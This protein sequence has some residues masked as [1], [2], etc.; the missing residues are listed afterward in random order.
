VKR[1]TVLVTLKAAGPL[2]TSG[3]GDLNRGLQ[4]IF[5][6]DAMGKPIL[7]ASHIKGKLLEALHEL[8]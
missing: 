3:G 1:Y 6:K 4:Q 2:L 7:Q 5:L 8:S